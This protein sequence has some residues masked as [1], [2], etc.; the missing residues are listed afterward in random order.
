MTNP[1]AP[2]SVSAGHAS[3]TAAEAAITAERAVAQLLSGPPAVRAEQVAERLLA[4]QGQDPR[5]ARL[6]VRVR[7]Q[8]LSAADVDHALTVDRSL[9]ISW[10]NRGTLHLVRS[11]DYWLL[12]R[13]TTPQ[14]ET[15]CARR[16]TQEGIPPAAAD[17][18]AGLIERFLDR[19][20]PLTR[21]Q[22]AERLESAGVRTQGQALVF[23]MFLTSLRGISV[24]GPMIGKQHAHVLARDWLGAPP[25]APDR[26]TALAWL[27]R[28]YLAGHAP[29]TERDLAKWA[30]L[31]LRDAR[32]GLR[33]IAPELGEGEDGVVRL[34]RQPDGTA[35]A[36]GPEP[37]LPPP[38][39]LGVFDP[40]LHGW[41]SRT[42]VLGRHEPEIVRGG[43]FGSFALVGGRA[44]GTWGLPGG[45]IS[46]TLLEKVSAADRR[47]LETDA[48]DVRRFLGLARP[49]AR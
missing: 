39:L 40:L 45:Q 5:G 41:Q 26:D 10:L 3:L 36:A 11:A 27:A 22:L 15:A 38:R 9:V 6:A 25:A 17:R 34:A 42:A 21:A 43:M 29:A 28:R 2:P 8:G 20:G 49:P 47:A 18:A 12:H 35:L 37:A 44:V 46:L 16:L 19:D 32:R 48:E 13:L 23:L 4:I 14:L 33:G 7:S 1:P 24:R 30:G 31:P